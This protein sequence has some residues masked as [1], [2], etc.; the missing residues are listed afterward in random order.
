MESRCLDMIDH[1]YD[2]YHPQQLLGL[3]KGTFS[4][5]QQFVVLGQFQSFQ[6]FLTRCDMS[7][8]PVVGVIDVVG[9][10][11]LVV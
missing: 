9:L 6:P 10:V 1:G 11:N 5:S 8:V 4:R 3:E 7:L 2:Y